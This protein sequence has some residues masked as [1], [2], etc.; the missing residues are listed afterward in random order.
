[1]CS[2]AIVHRIADPGEWEPSPL[3]RSSLVGASGGSRCN[4]R[5][6]NGGA[7]PIYRRRLS[8]HEAVG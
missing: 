2:R 8:S 4:R 6:P 7:V 1:M 3:G 5:V